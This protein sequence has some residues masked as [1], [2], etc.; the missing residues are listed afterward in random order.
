MEVQMP[1]APS[2][3]SDVGDH[4]VAAV[5]LLHTGNISTRLQE[6]PCQFRIVE[7]L[8]RLN[9]RVGNNQHV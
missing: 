9:M 8:K 3:L 5:Q 2:V 4:P 7:V 1:D 6:T